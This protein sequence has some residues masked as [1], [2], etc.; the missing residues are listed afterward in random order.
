M[1]KLPVSLKEIG[2]GHVLSPAAIAELD[3]KDAAIAKAEDDADLGPRTKEDIEGT[4]DDDAEAEA[5]ADDVF[6]PAGTLAAAK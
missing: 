3:A 6:A 4:A 1:K 5:E 2:F